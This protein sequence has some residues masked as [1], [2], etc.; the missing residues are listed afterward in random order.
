[1][2]QKKLEIQ[3]KNNIDKHYLNKLD[4]LINDKKKYIKKIKKL[5]LRHNNIVNTKTTKAIKN[6][7]T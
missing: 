4:N 2:I 1:M 5:L 3:Y 7:K 6:I